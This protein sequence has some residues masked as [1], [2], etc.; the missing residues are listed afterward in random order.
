MVERKKLVPVDG[1]FD[2]R[3]KLS[4]FEDLSKYKESQLKS[5]K[6]N[7]KVPKTLKTWYKKEE[8]FY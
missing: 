8:N 4:Y 5:D 1:L 2:P 6:T 7:H 3:Y